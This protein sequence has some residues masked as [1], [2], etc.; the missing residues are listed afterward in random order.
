[1]DMNSWMY[2]VFA[3]FV[4]LFLYVRFAPVKG[5]RTLKSEQFQAELESADKP[6]LID[7]REPAEFKAGH[8]PGA[9]NIPLSQLQA[10]IHEIPKDRKLLLYCR[11]GM[12]SKTA[13]KILLRHQYKELAHLGGGISAWRGRVSK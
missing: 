1:M 7:V 11:S 10:R 4:A 12:R 6:L 2:F 13:A 5:L 3:A 8:I 9:R